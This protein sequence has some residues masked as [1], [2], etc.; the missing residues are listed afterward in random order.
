VIYYKRT[1]LSKEEEHGATYTS[2]DELLAQSDFISIHTPLTDATRTLYEPSHARK[3]TCTR[4]RP[5][6]HAPHA[7]KHTRTHRTHTSLMSSGGMAWIGHILGR[8]QFAKMKRGV[9]IINTGTRLI[10]LTTFLQRCH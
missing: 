5:P 8:D 6:A 9:Y 3:H 10:L 7:H 2:L 4:T 1:P